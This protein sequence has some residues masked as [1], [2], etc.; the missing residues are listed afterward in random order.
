MSS[1][2]A[3]HSAVIT[4]R[5]SVIRLG[6]F[7]P[8]PGP[9]D[10]RIDSSTGAPARPADSARHAR[11]A[12]SASAQFLARG[13]LLREQIVFG[14]AGDHSAVVR[15]TKPRPTGRGHPR[16]TRGAGRP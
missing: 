15:P 4:R 13:V 16:G 7:T 1:R 6:M 8:G 10:P 14:H 12:A 3:M 11:I 2:L 9:P 5:E